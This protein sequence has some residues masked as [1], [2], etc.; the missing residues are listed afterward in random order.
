MNQAEDGALGLEIIELERPP[1]ERF[2]YPFSYDEAGLGFTQRWWFRSPVYPESQRV[3]LRVLGNEIEVARMELNPTTGANH[4]A[5][6]PPLGLVAFDI[7]FLEVHEEHRLRGLGTQVMGLLEHRY[8]E[9]RFI[10]YSENADHFWGSLG[11]IR[12]LHADPK[13]ARWY[14]PLYVQPERRSS[15]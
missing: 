14:R 4:Y 1:G 15:K 11:W 5:N 3:F 2:W 10:A 9:H 12:H 8:P 6:V 7:S 13:E